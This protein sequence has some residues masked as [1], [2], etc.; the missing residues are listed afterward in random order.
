M[1]NSC[2]HPFTSFSRRNKFRDGRPHVYSPTSDGISISHV[3]P[4]MMRLR[5]LSIECHLFADVSRIHTGRVCKKKK[6][7]L[8]QSRLSRVPRVFVGPFP[9]HPAILLVVGRS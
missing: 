6:L 5:P 9:R 3:G 1:C 8:R 7:T 2:A 4:N